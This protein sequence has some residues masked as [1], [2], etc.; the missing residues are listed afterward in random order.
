MQQALELL[1]NTFGYSEFRNNQMEIIEDLI[2]GENALVLMPT[3]GG[4]S[5]CYQIPAIL[6]KGTGVIVSP[7][8][9]LMQDQ[10]DALNQLGIKAAFLNST[11]SRDEQ[12]IVEQQLLDNAI[13]LLYIA[14]ERLLSEYSLNLISQA[15]ISLFAIDEAHCVSQWGHD[16]RPE[17]QKL[18]ILAERF[19]DTPR[20]ALTATA[21]QRTRDEM[22]HIL[23]LGSAGVYI[24]SFDRKNIHY[25]IEEATNGRARLVSFIKENH[26]KD[27]GIV[28]CLSRKKVESVAEHLTNQGFTALPYHAGLSNQLRHHN[29]KRFLQESGIIIV[30]TIAFGMGIDKPDV[31]FVAHLNLPKNIESYYQ[32]T[33]RAGR[34]GKPANAW[35]NYGLQDVITLSQMMQQSSGSEEY[36][37]ITQHKLNA[38]LG[39]CELVTC[40]R[41]PLLKYFAEELSEPCGNCDNCMNPPETW[42]ATVEA[43]KALSTAYRSGQSFG[44]EY[45]TKILLGKLDDRI[46]K[47]QHDKISTWGIGEK[48]TTAEWRSIYRQLIAQNYLHTNVERYGALELTEK[49]RPL[50]KGLED[51]FA[52]KYVAPQKVSK[53]GNAKISKKIRPSDEPLYEALKSLRKQLAEVQ[54]LPPYMIFHDSTLEQMIADRPSSPTELQYINGVGESKLA[55]YGKEFLTV[56]KQ[57]PRPDVLNNQLSDTVNDTLELYL[58]E[59]STEEIADKRGLTESSIYSHLAQAIAVGL[60]EC[61]Q[62]LDLEADDIEEIIQT[63]NFLDISADSSLKPLF[64]EFDGQYSYGELKCI[65]SAL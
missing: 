56:I 8:I 42:N 64:E 19:P 45:L 1:R 57:F 18:S 30:A 44:V 17:Y 15:E 9:A 28:Y 20:M 61:E 16:F 13:E 10:V 3:G 12:Q 50:L 31:R 65:I 23:G 27:S 54:E 25:T 49:A 34:D 7:L 14:P 58:Q 46:E 4:K 55:R 33:G 41:Q 24:D 29:Q 37:R 40:R 38:M 26:S 52:R 62:V 47:N 59:L 5:L 35:M 63:A 21:D 43:Q 36:K 22:A 32:E 48:L 60:L 39:L 11:M 6:R 53:K 2:A 51:F